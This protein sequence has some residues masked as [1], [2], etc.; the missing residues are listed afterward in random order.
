MRAPWPVL[1][2]TVILNPLLLL[3]EAVC[4]RND[5]DLSA[6]GQ[7]SGETLLRR[8]RELTFP[9]GSAFVVSQIAGCNG[10]GRR[11]SSFVTLDFYEVVTA[12]L[13]E[14]EIG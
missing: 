13:A 2:L 1:I 12:C 5:T 8:R 14:I 6:A 10:G 4:H 7:R 3:G 9:K 11:G